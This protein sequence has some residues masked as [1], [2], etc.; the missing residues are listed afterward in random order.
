MTNNHDNNLDDEVVYDGDS[1]NDKKGDDD[2]DIEVH[3]V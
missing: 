2:G 3:C 1:D